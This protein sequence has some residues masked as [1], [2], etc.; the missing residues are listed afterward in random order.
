M[1][2]GLVNGE[3]QSQAHDKPRDEGS[4]AIRLARRVSLDRDVRVHL[5][6]DRQPNSPAT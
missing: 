1:I 2:D 5:G 6:H 4:Y 3:S